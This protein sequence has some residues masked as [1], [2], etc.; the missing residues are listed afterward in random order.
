[1]DKAYKKISLSCLLASLL[2]GCT[3]NPFSNAN[4]PTGSPVGAAVGAGVGAGGA[5][6][7]GGS[8]SLIASAGIVGGIVGYYT[9]TLRY[10]SGGVMQGGGDVYTIGQYV[11]IYI[12]TDKI[13]EPNTAEFLPQANS[14]L[15]SAAAV[16]LRYPNN[17]IIIS[18]N[19]TGFGSRKWERKLSEQRAAKVASYLWNAGVNNFKNPG[20]DTRKLNYVG[21]GNFFPIATTQ[22]NSGI[23]RNGRIQITSYPSDVDL[24]IDDRHKAL[25]NIGSLDDEVGSKSEVTVSPCGNGE[26]NDNCY[27]D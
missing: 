20:I 6:L 23:R 21:Y 25:H 10:D 24:H 12:P 7:F 3:F 4:K 15:D 27:K 1:M 22:T 19:T 16:L 14:I 18:G 8:K 2:T 5:A 13:F 26:T 9:T 11:G 17:N